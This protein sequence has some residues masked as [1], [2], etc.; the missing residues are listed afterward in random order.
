M[1]VWCC[2]L[3]FHELC[4]RTDK[5]TTAPSVESQLQFCRSARLTSSCPSMHQGRA[6]AACREKLTLSFTRLWNCQRSA[7]PDVISYK[8]PQNVP[9][10]TKRR[11]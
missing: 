1:R 7:C 11:V 10:T 4:R 5:E 8:R 9:N 2:F 3:P 6:S